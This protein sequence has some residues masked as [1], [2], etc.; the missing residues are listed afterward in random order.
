MLAVLDGHAATLECS[1]LGSYSGAYIDYRHAVLLLQK[2]FIHRL[3]RLFSRP[4]RTGCSVI[5]AWVDVSE[6]MYGEQFSTADL[7]IFPFPLRVSRQLRFVLNCHRRRLRFCL[8]GLKY[9]LSRSAL[10]LLQRQRRD[11]SMVSIELEASRRY[12]KM[13]LEGA[14]QLVATSDEFEIASFAM[15]EAPIAGGVKVINTAHGVGVYCPYVTYSEFYTFNDAQAQ[16]YRAKNP[17]V[18]FHRRPPA[19]TKIDLPKH[20]APHARLALVLIHQPFDTHGALLEAAANLRV[21]AEL[22]RVARRLGADYFIKLHPNTPQA[23]AESTCRDL[24]GTG[25]MTWS[26]LTLHRPIFFVFNST[27]YFELQEAGPVF[28]YGGATF[29]PEIYFGSGCK[30]FNEESIERLV[31]VL[32]QPADWAAVVASQA[33]NLA[34][35][36]AVHTGTRA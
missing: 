20:V 19:N 3:F 15:Y 36:F 6:A 16:F 7:R 1:D 14:P 2:A 10:T 30:L 25:L 18:V 34:G 27:T 35:N 32:R 8:D 28:V 22:A 17:A 12:G 26:G 4:I 13:L 9:S 24:G 31:H 29:F 23:A 21:G 5:R 33:E 11:L